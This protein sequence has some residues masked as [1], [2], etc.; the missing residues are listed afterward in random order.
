MRRA[1]RTDLQLNSCMTTTT[2]L[3]TSAMKAGRLEKAKK[4][5]LYI[6]RHEEIHSLLLLLQTVLAIIIVPTH[7]LKDTV[8]GENHSNFN[9]CLFTL[10]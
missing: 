6:K 5:L 1:L 2:H 4:V 8:S 9:F 7:V 3:L 10:K